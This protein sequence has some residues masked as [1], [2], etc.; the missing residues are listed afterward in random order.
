MIDEEDEY[1]Q[2]NKEGPLRVHRSHSILKKKIL[3]DWC[4]EH[5]TRNNVG[6]IIVAI[7]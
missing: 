4:E 5:R 2:K 7:R 1:A 6:T 3:T